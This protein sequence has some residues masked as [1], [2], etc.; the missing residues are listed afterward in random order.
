[1]T[2]KIGDRI[3]FVAHWSSFHGMRG[4][5][6]QLRPHVMVLIDGDTYPIRVGER[7]VIVD[8]IPEA[9]P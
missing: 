6:Q 5:V 8:A 1:V 7:E 2:I 9:E 4:V 3:R